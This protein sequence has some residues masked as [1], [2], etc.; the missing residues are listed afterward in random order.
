MAAYRLGDNQAIGDSIHVIDRQCRVLKRQ[1]IFRRIETAGGDEYWIL[2]RGAIH[3][4]G[5][6]DE[7]VTHDVIG[8]VVADA[9]RYEVTPGRVIRSKGSPF[10]QCANQN[11]IGLETLIARLESI[12]TRGEYDSFIH[13]YIRYSGELWIVA[14]QSGGG[15]VQKADHLQPSVGIAHIEIVAVGAQ[16]LCITRGQCLAHQL[17]TPIFLEKIYLHAVIAGGCKKIVISGIN[18]Q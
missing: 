14:D 1:L 7:R 3:H 15:R 9:I 5:R 11:G 17:E 4:G 6:A 13:C 18:S 12:F 2:A 16:E 10:I 8:K